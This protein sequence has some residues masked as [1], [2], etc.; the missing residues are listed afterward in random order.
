MSNAPPPVPAELAELVQRL[1][2]APAADLILALRADQVARWRR[3]QPLRAEAYLA[4]FPRVAASG[5]AALLLVCG[6]MLLRMQ[7]GGTPPLA[8]LQ[9]RFPHF[10][11]VL[12][13]QYDLRQNLTGG[14]EGT[15]AG[16]DSPPVALAGPAA[17][18]QS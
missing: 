17:S 4:A 8:D 15:V 2:A 10:A 16:P 7:A 13:V 9:Q 12:A 18:L 5:D 11:A 14:G 6:E 3:D 1:E